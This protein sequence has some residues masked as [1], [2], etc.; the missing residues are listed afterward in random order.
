MAFLFFVFFCVFIG[1][2]RVCVLR[3][4][5][6]NARSAE[7]K[8]NF[9]KSRDYQSKILFEKTLYF[10]TVRPPGR[11]VKNRLQYN[12]FIANNITNNLTKN[13][14]KLLTDN[15]SGVIHEF[16]YQNSQFLTRNEI[17]SLFVKNMKK[18]IFNTMYSNYAFNLLEEFN[19]IFNEQNTNITYNSLYNTIINNSKNPISMIYTC[20]HSQ[21]FTFFETGKLVFKLII[22]LYLIFFQVTR[23]LLHFKNALTEK[24]IRNPHSSYYTYSILELSNW[25][26]IRENSLCKFQTLFKELAPTSNFPL[27]YNTFAHFYQFLKVKKLDVDDSRHFCYQYSHFCSNRTRFTTS[28]HDDRVLYSESIQNLN[29]QFSCMSASAHYSSPTVLTLF[30]IRT[31]PT[32]EDEESARWGAHRLPRYPWQLQGIRNHTGYPKAALIILGLFLLLFS[33]TISPSSDGTSSDF[34]HLIYLGI[35]DSVFGDQHSLVNFTTHQNSL[36]NLVRPIIGYTRDIT[37]NET[38]HANIGTSY[39]LEAMK[40]RTPEGR[41]LRIIDTELQ[42]F[43]FDSEE[44]YLKIFEED[45][46]DE[47]I[48]SEDEESRMEM[49]FDSEEERRGK[50]MRTKKICARSILAHIEHM[51]RR[52][53][54]YPIITG[55]IMH[56]VV[57]QNT[58][59]RNIYK[60]KFLNI[61][62]FQFLRISM[63]ATSLIVSLLIHTTIHNNKYINYTLIA[64]MYHIE[65]FINFLKNMIFDKQYIETPAGEHDNTSNSSEYNH[66]RHTMRTSGR[67]RSKSVHNE[68]IRDENKDDGDGNQRRYNHPQIVNSEGKIAIRTSR[69]NFDIYKVYTGYDDEED[70][71][72]IMLYKTYSAKGYYIEDI[73]QHENE[74]NRLHIT[75]RTKQEYSEAIK[76]L[77]EDSGII[78]NNISNEIFYLTEE[79]F[80]QYNS[81]HDE[82]NAM[83]KLP[84]AKDVKYYTWTEGNISNELEKINLLE[85]RN[86]RTIAIPTLAVATTTPSSIEQYN[87]IIGTIYALPMEI[88]HY[89]IEDTTDVETVTISV[90]EANAYDALM[91]LAKMNIPCMIK[92]GY[93][94]NEENV[95][96]EIWHILNNK[97]ISRLHKDTKIQKNDNNNIYIIL[98]IQIY[99]ENREIE[100]S[101]IKNYLYSLAKDENTFFNEITYDESTKL[102]NIRGF[103]YAT[104]FETL[105]ICMQEQGNNIC[106]EGASFM[107]NGNEE[108]FINELRQDRLQYIR[109]PCNTTT[110]KCMIDKAYT[111]DESYTATR[112]MIYKTIKNYKYYIEDIEEYN[113]QQLKISIRTSKEHA[114]TVQ[115]SFME[116]GIPMQD[117]EDETFE[118]TDEEKCRF[119]EKL[120]EWK[121]LLK[122]PIA[123][124]IKQYVWTEDN[125]NKELEEIKTYEDYEIQVV[126]INIASLISSTS[127]NDETYYQ[128]LR[129]IRQIIPSN[130]EFTIIE[131]KENKASIT[132]YVMKTKFDEFR[133]S[134]ITNNIPFTVNDTLMITEENVHDIIWQRLNNKSIDQSFKGKV[135]FSTKQNSLFI[136]FDIEDVDFETTDMNDIIYNVYYYAKEA[137]IYV[138]DIT[139]H[140]NI[141][142]YNVSGFANINELNTFTRYM[143]T[144]DIEVHIKGATYMQSKDEK[145][146]FTKIRNLRKQFL[147]INIDTSIISFNM[148]QIYDDNIHA[149]KMMVYKTINSNNY[150]VENIT[151]IDGG[152]S[153]NII[154]RTYSEHVNALSK[155]L[156]TLGINITSTTQET[157]TVSYNERKELDS[158]MKERNSII[159]ESEFKNIKKYTWSEDNIKNT[160]DSI[161]QY[162]GAKMRYIEIPI[163][164]VSR[165]SPN[166]E[167]E[168]NIAYRRIL[169]LPINIGYFVN[170]Y[171]E[172]THTFII[173]IHEDELQAFIDNAVEHNL[174]Y[175]KRDKYCITDENINDIVH[176][177]LDNNAIRTTYNAGTG[178]LVTYDIY[179]QVKIIIY[180]KKSNDEKLTKSEFYYDTRDIKVLI[181]EMMYDLSSNKLLLQTIIKPSQYEKMKEILKND[182]ISIKIIGSTPMLTP[183]EQLELERLEHERLELK[184]SIIKIVK[185]KFIIMYNINEEINYDIYKQMIYKSCN[186]E[187]YFIN[188]IAIDDTTSHHLEVSITM[189]KDKANQIKEIMKNLKIEFT[190]FEEE[191]IETTQEEIEKTKT[192][193][194]ERKNMLEIIDL[195]TVK[196]MTFSKTNE[197]LVFERIQSWDTSII[198]EYDIIISPTPYPTDISNNILEFVKGVGELMPNFEYW[199]V[200]KS[201]NV[202][203]R[204]TICTKATNDI[205]IIIHLD[206]LNI[207]FVRGTTYTIE[208]HNIQQFIWTYLNNLATEHTHIHHRIQCNRKK[209][210]IRAVHALTA[211]EEMSDIY[212]KVTFY[213]NCRNIEI[214]LENID[215]K[216]NGTCEVTIIGHLKH[217]R[218]YIEAYDAQDSITITHG[219]KIETEEERQKLNLLQEERSRI[220]ET[221]IEQEFIDT[222]LDIKKQQAYQIINEIREMIENNKKSDIFAKIA[223]LARYRNI[224]LYEDND[225]HAHWME[226]INTWDDMFTSKEGDTYTYNILQNNEN[227]ISTNMIKCPYCDIYYNDANSIQKHITNTHNKKIRH[228]VSFALQYVIMMNNE[229][230]SSMQAQKGFKCP[231]CTYVCTNYEETYKHCITSHKN[232]TPNIKDGIVGEKQNVELHIQKLHEEEQRMQDIIEQQKI[233]A[234]QAFIATPIQEKAEN[235]N[236]ILEKIVNVNNSESIKDVQ[237]TL[238]P[239]VGLLTDSLYTLS[240]VVVNG[241]NGKNVRNEA[242]MENSDTPSTEEAAYAESIAKL[243]SL[244][245]NDYIFL[246]HGEKESHEAKFMINCPFCNQSCNNAKW[247]NEHIKHAH[248]RYNLLKSVGYVWTYMTS[249]MTHVNETKE[250]YFKARE[251][252]R[253]GK[254]GFQH[255][256]RSEVV[257]HIKHAH[258]ISKQD[259]VPNVQ[260]GIVGFREEA[261][262]LY[263]KLFQVPK[264]SPKILEKMDPTIYMLMRNR[265]CVATQTEVCTTSQT[266]NRVDTETQSGERRGGANNTNNNHQQNDREPNTQQEINTVFNNPVLKIRK[267]LKSALVGCEN[268]SNCCYMNSLMQSLYN[269]KIFKDTIMRNG[270]QVDNI[271]TTL[272]NIF[273]ALDVKQD[274]RDAWYINLS[275]TNIYQILQFDEHVQSDPRE[276][277]TR[278]LDVIE[279]TE[280]EKDTA[281]LFDFKETKT[282]YTGG[283]ITTTACNTL[284]INPPG[285]G[286]H[287]TE[288]Y[289]IE[290]LIK[291]AIDICDTE[292]DGSI[293]AETH[294]KLS[295]K[296]LCINVGRTEYIREENRMQQNLYKLNIKKKLIFGENIYVLNSVIVHHST[297]VNGGHFTTYVFK[298]NKVFHINDMVAKKENININNDYVSCDNITED[299]RT[300]LVIYERINYGPDAP[301]I[302]NPDPNSGT[303]RQIQI[304]LTHENQIHS[305]S[306][307][308][309]EEIEHQDTQQEMHSVPTIEHNEQEQISIVNQEINSAQSTQDNSTQHTVQTQ[310]DTQEVYDKLERQIPVYELTDEEIIHIQI[311]DNEIKQELSET[312]SPEGFMAK[313]RYLKENNSNYNTMPNLH[314]NQ[315]LKDISIITIALLKGTLPIKKN[316]K[317]CGYPN[318]PT[319]LTSGTMRTSHYKKVHKMNT[320]ITYTPFEEIL[321]ILG[322]DITTK[323][324]KNENSNFIKY[325]L[326]R[327]PCGTCEYTSH[328]C[329]NMIEHLCTKHKEAWKSVKPLSA[330]F[331]ILWLMKLNN[332]PLTLSNI[333][334]EGKALQCKKCGWCTTG[335][336]GG[337]IHVSNVHRTRQTGI[338]QN[339]DMH[340]TFYERDGTNLTPYIGAEGINDM[341]YWVNKNEESTQRSEVNAQNEIESSQNNESSISQHTDQETEQQQHNTQ[342]ID[343]ANISQD[344]IQN[345]TQD[346]DE[347]VTHEVPENENEEEDGD[348]GFLTDKQIRRAMEWHQLYYNM[349]ESIP[350]FKQE[351]KKVLTSS[352]KSAIKFQ[353]MPILYSLL[354]H[355]IPDNAP[356]EEV[357]NGCLCRCSYLIVENAKQALGIMK[358][359]NDSKNRSYR[360]ANTYEEELH[361]KTRA[362]DAGE[363][364]AKAITSIEHFRQENLEVGILQN[365]EDQIIDDI[366]EQAELLSEDMQMA[367][368]NTNDMTREHVINKVNDIINQGGETNIKTFIE[369][370]DNDI[371]HMEQAHRKV[372]MKKTRDLFRLS[373]NRAMKYYVDPHI[374]PNCP[375]PI[376][377]I[378]KELAERWQAPEWDTVQYTSEWPII[379]RLSETDKERIISCMQDVETFKNVISTRDITSAHGTDGIGYWALKLCPEL[380]SEMMVTISKII[381]KYG[382]MPTTW[383]ISRTILLYKKGDERDLKNWRPLTIA[384]C[385]YRT[386]TCALAS[387]LQT[388]NMYSTKLFD[389]NQKGF[390][391]HKDGCLEHSN[392]ITEAIC[393]ANRNAK[394]IYIAALDLRDAFGSVPH[395]YIK[396]VLSE[397]QF[398]EEII[399][400]ISDSYDNGTAKVRVGSEESDTINIHKGVKQGCPLSPLI[401]NFCMNPLLSKLEQEGEGYSIDDDCTLKVQAYADDIIL[402]SSTREGLQNNLNIVDNFMKYAKVT[403]N[404]SK[405]HTMSYVIRNC[406]RV[407]EEAPF[408][409]AGDDIPVCDLSEKIEYLGT[410]AATTNRIRKHGAMEA[411]EDTKRLISKIGESLLSL[412][413][414]IYAI[415]TFAIP[416]LD[417]VLTN[418]RIN[419]ETCNEIDRLIRVTINNHVKGVHLPVGLFYTHWKDGGFSILKLRERAICLR[420]KTFMALYNTTSTKVR[421]A[422]RIYTE[423]ERA[424][425]HIETINEN[426]EE[427]FLNWK[428]PEKLKKGTDSIVVH[429]MRSAVKLGIRITVNAETKDIEI[430][431]KDLETDD[432]QTPTIPE[433]VTGEP[434]Y[435]TVTLTT[436]KELLLYAAR[437][438][439][440][441]YREELVS[442]IGVGHSFVDIKESPYANKFIGD[443][444]HPLNDTI[445]R[446]IIKARCNMLFTGALALKTKVSAEMIPCCPYC[447]TKGGDTISHRL[448]G[449]LNSRTAQTKRHNN[450][451]NIILSYMA[452]RLGEEMHRR[453]NIT[454]NLDGKHIDEEYKDLK[455]DIVAWDKDKIILVEFSC[456]YA[457]YG[458]NGSTLEKVYQEK[459]TKYAN[460]VKACKDTYKKKVSLYV[461]I[462]S[463]LGAVYSK[464]ED[465]IKKLLRIS[466]NENK[467]FSTILRRIS[468]ASCIASYF[469]FNR[470]KFSEFIPKTN[471]N[472]ST[473]EEIGEPNTSGGGREQQNAETQNVDEDEEY[474]AIEEGSNGEMVEEEDSSEYSFES[475]EETEEEEIGEI[476]R[477]DDRNIGTGSTHGTY[478][479]TEERREDDNDGNEVSA[480]RVQNFIDD[481]DSSEVDDG[482]NSIG[483]TST[484]AHSND[485]FVNQ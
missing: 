307:T 220:I 153:Y 236:N 215:R 281:R 340:Y 191:S 177:M 457:N 350:K 101:E 80:A 209:L 258:I 386:W 373:P 480:R 295:S 276:V 466:D 138:N 248:Q 241:F 45:T 202:Q 25:R 199:V 67:K 437:S 329:E 165:T 355:E 91:S 26:R 284:E 431:A 79:E 211:K 112:I 229:N 478:T 304:P 27:L 312:N 143:Q 193:M 394:D 262:A 134:L 396:F 264:F 180:D 23:R 267:K 195:N 435:D 481:S 124:C 297:E 269:I 142:K 186:S 131:D 189:L 17:R 249:S 374:S 234:R 77:L 461:I 306:E 59:K 32:G 185:A 22:V 443:Y 83:M 369:N 7:Q 161:A 52:R 208:N 86:I 263:D 292:Q 130:I 255:T 372:V 203:N 110:M 154:L 379:H 33:S 473:Q 333:L 353:I 278:L 58:N 120:N 254:C 147:P 31:T 366:V 397:M 438:M 415:K 114:G 94:L 465:E 286:I 448:N 173:S 232:K 97:S 235:V 349:Q 484:I 98:E 38:Y 364:I 238:T 469:I 65:K 389:E 251:C 84:T 382:F 240:Q 256:D 354:K 401:F 485:N 148:R 274:I 441:K 56:K 282:G 326:F 115:Q 82:R 194:N 24:S 78:I 404:T 132:I 181:R 196:H 285:G 321:E 464:S 146:L 423:S 10:H 376:N 456:P 336:T 121:S 243:F 300:A 445:A 231:Y 155:I 163:S 455:P 4:E 106:I 362:R 192:K 432:K 206:A 436:P 412:N 291:D 139:K 109:T 54:V 88:E 100:E 370:A 334:Y 420:A 104:Q 452:P 365:R 360:P 30:K 221:I 260:N 315:L 222:P 246:H 338:M 210:Y 293:S 392:M 361:M 288:T 119:E 451:Q 470:L 309:Q 413:Q 471:D 205:P 170:G 233:D 322:I 422:M 424:H 224:K 458:R 330:T 149:H 418:K 395:E 200:E 14:E 136:I 400:L 257:R 226:Y 37:N 407:Y 308:Q 174:P 197:K 42:N 12:N 108:I 459:R 277:L 434:P 411:I 316:E 327:C 46:E 150:Y 71:T 21:I 159:K 310:G 442:N 90:N 49:I 467:L 359:K 425:R 447:G 279:N 479:G 398:P 213:N 93:T 167:Y 204:A 53:G 156:L 367:I 157:I 385:L 237:L 57:Q 73:T 294:I 89:V 2:S 409:I 252:Y 320:C 11:S 444:K 408:Q 72:K 48:D 453:T 343:S 346:I 107:K 377:E 244:N 158:N 259:E 219:F 454:V 280:N 311:L 228:D 331:K 332:K 405:C 314:T 273:R 323:T 5:D 352:M 482:E 416:K 175:K 245:I 440:T 287:M 410:D 225:I 345:E 428:I 145:M 375:I 141:N 450:I 122:D 403:V 463:S 271:L 95:F 125:K 298:G 230:V 477:K 439:R 169:E 51:M 85:N 446:W 3:R 28:S 302:P 356:K 357:V 337:S 1:N 272:R 178:F 303:E 50:M 81:N 34:K 135:T 433:N 168:L 41:M 111:D 187:G 421:Q 347:N 137:V 344:T 275:D 387:V 351:R 380:G 223:D 328:K 126:F 462:V 265:E 214:Y 383:N 313:I 39:M 270:M 70:L 105:A 9:P 391:K 476:A 378:Q 324:N 171:D 253:C 6:C 36:Q 335:K 102:F 247:I 64:I 29:K 179:L 190:H 268:K 417:Y 74:D 183:E 283:T 384:S 217:I 393:D 250:E 184:K 15:S 399:A 103:T 92:D 371:Q 172:D 342:H 474:G 301:I 242:I 358:K 113:Q 201:K 207:P 427:A 426:E 44:D 318:C 40:A 341:N 61:E 123:K 164:T 468:L 419:L 133:D 62:D 63:I 317:I 472:S 363:K 152:N 66:T 47:D 151:P 388:I 127:Y 13:Y 75:L 60:P 128:I 449:C 176:E 96:Q 69:I 140:E 261:N 296:I 166:D 118:F 305:S 319:L 19:I 460:L 299:G 227:S 381:I 429:A 99:N 216:E 483:H 289:N 144:Y 239:Y 188:S 182:N 87:E 55:W 212:A 218:A 475:E 339:I 129:S 160:Y 76:Q 162:I 390:I 368:F 402:F 325:P 20:L 430:V 43:D 406:R 16:Q 414:K 35:Q 348:T 18:F 266:P 117:I 8:L 68:N 198:Q 116:C 290:D